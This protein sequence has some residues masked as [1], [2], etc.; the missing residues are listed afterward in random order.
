MLRPFLVQ[1]K[2]ESTVFVCQSFLRKLLLGVSL[3]QLAHYPPGTQT[4]LY[5][6]FYLVKERVC[7]AAYSHNLA[8]YKLS[9]NTIFRLFSKSLTGVFPPCQPRH[10][11]NKVCKLALIT[12]PRLACKQHA[13]LPTSTAF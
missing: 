4:Q 12:S 7:I 6:F 1:L 13:K 11:I 3:L 8:H 10:R 2:T 5:L 9:V